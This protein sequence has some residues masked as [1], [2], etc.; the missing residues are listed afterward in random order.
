MGAFPRR[1]AC[2]ISS[3]GCSSIATH[4]DAPFDLESTPLRHLLSVMMLSPCLRSW[5]RSH[6]TRLRGD[7]QPHGTP[8]LPETAVLHQER[9]CSAPLCGCVSGGMDYDHDRWPG[10]DAALPGR[11]NDMSGAAG[12]G[13]PGDS[14]GE[15]CWTCSFRAGA[16]L[17]RL[18]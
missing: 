1:S 11:T 12:G 2:T 7:C 13:D 8:I 4:S 10:R 15:S 18:E 14:G 6:P 5:R 17:P 3:L 16:S 9:V